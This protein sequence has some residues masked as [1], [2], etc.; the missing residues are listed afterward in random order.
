MQRRSGSDEHHGWSGRQKRGRYVYLARLM[1]IGIV[2]LSAAAC[3]AP[4]NNA[5]PELTSNIV[6]TEME[7]GPAAGEETERRGLLNTEWRFARDLPEES[8]ADPALDDSSWEVVTLPHTPRVEPLAS[9]ISGTESHGIGGIYR[10]TRSC[11]GERYSSNS[12]AP[13]KW[14]MSG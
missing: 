3:A 9:T 13:C 7:R 12:R 8:Y 5:F 2:M 14:P 1:R 4:E 10:Q 6:R 11:L